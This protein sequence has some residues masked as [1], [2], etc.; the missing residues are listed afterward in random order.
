[1]TSAVGGG[2]GSPKR[3]H[4]VQNQLICDSDKGGRGS[5]NPKML[6]TSY[7]DME[8]PLFESMRRMVE[9]EMSND[10]K[11]EPL[12][13]ES[14]QNTLKKSN[15]NKF[16]VKFPAKNISTFQPSK[17]RGSIEKCKNPTMPSQQKPGTTYLQK[18]KS[19]LSHFWLAR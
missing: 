2:G 4:M 13:T 16:P 12:I 5:K 6:R 18:L 10:V 7:M 14:I 15:E 11:V 1:M 17:E 8:A 9:N 19:D 3:R